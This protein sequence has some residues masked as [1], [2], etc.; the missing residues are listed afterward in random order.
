MGTDPL[1]HSLL[2]EGGLC[3]HWAGCRR[4]C[5]GG[6]PEPVSAPPPMSRN[7]LFTVLTNFRSA[8][9]FASQAIGLAR[10]ARARVLASE[11]ADTKM[12]R[13]PNRSRI[14]VAA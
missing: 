13:T 10:S 14:S 3:G 4:L 12:L 11:N 6:A 7:A 9:G 5:P 1:P 2:A 8:T